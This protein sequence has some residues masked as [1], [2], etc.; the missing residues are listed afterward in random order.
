MLR[1]PMQCDGLRHAVGSVMLASGRAC[2]TRRA[3]CD[4]DDGSGWLTF[5]VGSAALH[6]GEG[7]PM[8]FPMRGGVPERLNGTVLKT[9]GCK[10]RGFESHPL[11]Q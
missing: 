7:M 6:V 2:R 8:L 1:W 11:R 3:G 10:P 4:L 5:A 9:V